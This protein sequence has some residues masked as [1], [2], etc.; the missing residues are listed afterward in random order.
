MFWGINFIFAAGFAEQNQISE[1]NKTNRFF[2]SAKVDLAN[3]PGRI[4]DDSKITFLRADNFTALL[5]AG[6]VSVVMHNSDADKNIAENFER[7]R[8]FRGFSDE[9]LN[10]LGCPGTHF[11]AAGLWYA[12]SAD[13]KDE[14]NKDRSWT[15]MTALAITGLV[16]TGLKAAR[17]NDCPNGEPWAW[18]SGH[19]SSSFTV[20]SV[21]DE[22]YGPE[23]GIPAYIAASLVGWR[24]MDTRDH[25]GSDVLF[26]ATLGWV[27]GHTVAG[28]DKKLEVAGF[29]VLPYIATSS[30][31]AT[32][33]SLVKQF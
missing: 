9:S 20:A 5:L 19:T 22:F 27:V 15:M 17:H 12:A 25:W 2:E 33:V 13:K 23:V 32:G 21:L 10:I 11:A 6:G 3:W 28:K 7:H 4:I 29:D 8:T 18:P 24:M 26:G 31:S 30:D 1:P 14:L 16:T